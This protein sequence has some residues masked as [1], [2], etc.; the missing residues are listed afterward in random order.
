M[1]PSNPEQMA[2]MQQLMADPEMMELLSDPAVIEKM[3][4]LMSNPAAIYQ[5]MGDPT[6]MKIITKL[7]QLQMGG[8]GGGGGMGGMMGGMPGMGAGAPRAAASAAAGSEANIVNITSAAQ[9]ESLIAGAGKKPVIVD[10][11]A[12]WCG[13]CKMI[14]PE[15]A[16]LATENKD[17][18]IF[19]KVDGDANRALVQSKGVQGFP[20]FHFYVSGTLMESFSGADKSK[21]ANAVDTLVAQSLVVVNP[22]KQFPLRDEET[23]LYRDIKWEMITKKIVEVCKDIEEKKIVVDPKYILTEAE[24]KS[25]NSLITLLNDRT[26]YLNATISDAQYQVVDKLLSW[27]TSINGS[28]VHFI[29][30]LILHPH[31]AA[32]YAKLEGKENDAVARLCASG[33]DADKAIGARLVLWALANF[34]SRRVSSVA[35]S[36]RY[37]IVID[38]IT[39]LFKKYDDAAL[40][41]CCVN[42][43]INFAIVWRDQPGA[44]EAAKVQSL[45]CLME[46]LETEK[47]DAKIIFR[48]IVVLGT[49][50]YGD[51][52]CHSMAVDLELPRVVRAI[53]TSFATSPEVTASTTELLQLLSASTKR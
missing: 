25:M 53:A 41:A 45:A 8:M 14:A 38:T 49:L 2:L 39:T 4:S 24:T 52:G 34:F 36:Q 27:P 47:R 31:A 42:L 20:T 21:L 28:G 32:R 37:E 19:L 33:R 51:S 1:D 12:S 13:P 43:L 11:T 26:N 50:I 18:A 9:F 5:H 40:R 22:Y 30:M 48:I 3:Q 23:V 44:N 7:Q 15:F 6:V 16:R 17:T 35:M 10:F 29:R 46:M